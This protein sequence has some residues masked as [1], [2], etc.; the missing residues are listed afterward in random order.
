MNGVLRTTLAGGWGGRIHQTTTPQWPVKVQRS[1]SRGVAR[2][3]YSAARESLL[4]RMLSVRMLAAWAR[5]WHRGFARA[6]GRGL[7]LSFAPNPKR[8]P[9]QFIAGQVT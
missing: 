9:Y 3:C 8:S 5:L 6:R 1:R 2:H 4:M 7:R